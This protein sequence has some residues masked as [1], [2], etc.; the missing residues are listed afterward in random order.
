M[1]KENL[2]ALDRIAKKNSDAESHL[3]KIEIRNIAPLNT[4]QLKILNQ[5]LSTQEKSIKTK[6]RSNNSKAKVLK[7]QQK[8]TTSTNKKKNLLSTT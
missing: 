4:K 3:T 2:K 7:I 5:F 6:I 1:Q 8:I